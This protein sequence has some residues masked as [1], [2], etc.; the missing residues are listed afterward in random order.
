MKIKKILENYNRFGLISFI[1]TL[2]KKLRISLNF[3]DPI[4]QKRSYLSNKIQQITNGVVIDGLYK[5]TKF[6]KSEKCFL[7]KSSQLLGCYEE[8]VQNEIKVLK[9]NYNFE[10]L[11]NLG[12]GEGFHSVGCLNKKIVQNV[13][14]F[15]MVEKNRKSI[16]KNFELNEIQDNFSIFSKAN[17][18]F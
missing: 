3:F 4:Q 17:E 11:V 18:N 16:E 8:E 2:L 10:Y 14:N 7:A 13:I 9:E 6:I 15:E 1:R 5:N 12:A